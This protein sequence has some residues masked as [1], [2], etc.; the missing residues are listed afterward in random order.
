[1]QLIIQKTKDIPLNVL[2]QIKQFSP[3]NWLKEQLWNKQPIDTRVK[4]AR[5]NYA[6]YLIDDWKLITFAAVAQDNNF[7][8]NISQAMWYNP[9]TTAVIIYLFTVPKYQKKWNAKKLLDWLYS[10]VKEYFVWCEKLIRTTSSEYNKNLYIK[11]WANFISTI[12]LN[13]FLIHEW[14]NNDSYFTYSRP[15]ST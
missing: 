2:N 1:M 10:Y 3:W 8:K 7:N 11:Y 5:D 4:C 6:W 12:Q 14:I 9:L 15:M 13:E